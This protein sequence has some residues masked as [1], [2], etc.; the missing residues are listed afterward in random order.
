MVIAG[1]HEE[2]CGGPGRH[3][4]EHLLHEQVAAGPVQL[5]TRADPLVAGHLYDRVAAGE[6]AAVCAGHVN[7]FLTTLY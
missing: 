2:A 1:I 5:Q 3:I 7:T 6:H 4:Y